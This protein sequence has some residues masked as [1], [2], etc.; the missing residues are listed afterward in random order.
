MIEF[1]N[2]KEYLKCGLGFTDLFEEEMFHYLLKRDG[3]L[4]YNPK[5]KMMCDINL[6][7]VYYVEQVYTG[8]KSYL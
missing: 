3:K 7:P 1:D 5:I 2:L 4:F 6:T 8:S